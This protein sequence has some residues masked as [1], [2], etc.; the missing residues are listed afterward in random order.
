MMRETAIYGT[1]AIA[2]TCS[3]DWSQEVGSYLGTNRTLTPTVLLGMV[4]CRRPF[5]VLE[6]N[7]IPN[8]IDG[9]TNTEMQ[10]T[11]TGSAFK[12]GSAYFGKFGI[13]IIFETWNMNSVAQSQQAVGWTLSGIVDN[14]SY[15]WN[16]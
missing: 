3:G 2:I 5:Y 6:E 11:L 4:M 16:H 12:A 15:N 14:G 10:S 13:P 7:L 8:L 9:D 1:D